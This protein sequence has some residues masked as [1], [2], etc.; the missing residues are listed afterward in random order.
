MRKTVRE[1][2]GSDPNFIHKTVREYYGSDGQFHSRR[3][4]VLRRVHRLA[5]PADLEMQLHLIR[6]GI[7]HLRDLLS[8]R[9]LL[10]FLDEDFAVV[11]VCGQ[12]RGIVLDDDEL[13]VAAQ[14]AARVDDAARR[15]RA[16]G[17]ACAARDVDSLEICRLGKAGDDLALRRP[18]PSELIDI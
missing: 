10:P 5:E 12:I 9:D 11:R 8:A 6:I 13:A 7:A 18:C 15:A 3:R 17:F 1:Y 4:Q 2:Y 14:A 16:H